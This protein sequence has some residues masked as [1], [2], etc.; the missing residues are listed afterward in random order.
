MTFF[1]DNQS[2]IKWL[3]NAKTKH[4]EI[5]CHF[6][7]ELYQDEALKISYVSSE[8]QIADLLKKSLPVASYEALLE[9]IGN[10]SVSGGMLDSN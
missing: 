1:E 3:K 8:N 7:R 10:L 6:A 4:I 2:C 5:F 9:K